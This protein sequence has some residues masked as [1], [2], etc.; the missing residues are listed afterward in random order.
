MTERYTNKILVLYTVVIT[1]FMTT[2]MSSSVTLAL[3]AM[4]HEFDGSAVLA[5]DH[6][7]YLLSTAVF[8][9]PFGRLADIHGRR[10]IFLIGTI[11]YTIFT[12]AIALSVSMPMLIGCRILQGL[13]AAMIFS[14]NMAILSAAYPA[15]ERGRA[16]G[17]N[18]TATYVG[19]S[20]GPA[21]GG[22]MNH[23][24]GWRSIFY[25]IAMLGVMASLAIHFRLHDEWAE[26]REEKFDASGSILYALGLIAI[27]Y[28]LSSIS[29]SLWTP[30]L[31]LAGLGFMLLFIIR[32]SRIDAP[33]VQVH[34]FAKNK[35]FALSNLAALINYSANFAAGFLLSVYLQIVLGYSSYQAGLILL[36]QPIVVALLLPLPA[37]YPTA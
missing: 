30:Y 5:V 32:E 35:A 3:P 24:L 26:A 6:F 17:Y 2:F 20:L 31:L 15:E 36:P 33:I 1:S 7:P 25:L 22:V 37:P 23:L 21:L 27:L 29:S 11:L 9:L 10:K 8:L 16:L 34:L 28:G 13:S 18:V 14:T 12:L 19:L 4:S